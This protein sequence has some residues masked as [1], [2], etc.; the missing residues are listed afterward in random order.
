M[1]N[2]EIIENMIDIL[3]VLE[4]NT[5]NIKSQIIIKIAEQDIKNQKQTQQS[6]NIV[7]MQEGNELSSVRKDKNIGRLF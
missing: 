2:K 3:D 6:K 4:K 7:K 1:A 5:K